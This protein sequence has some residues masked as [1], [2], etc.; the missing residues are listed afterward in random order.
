MCCAA[1]PP[2]GGGELPHKPEE[3]MKRFK[4]STA[5]QGIPGA[6]VFLWGRQIYIRK[7]ELREDNSWPHSLQP[8]KKVLTTQCGEWVV[9]N[10][11]VETTRRRQYRKTPCERE[12]TSDMPE[13]L[14]ARIWHAITH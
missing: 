6:V 5:Q 10:S 11:H 7:E 13:C 3:S 8:E 4:N 1:H 12:Q 14:R 9:R 2:V